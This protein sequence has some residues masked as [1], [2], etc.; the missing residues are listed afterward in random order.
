MT[1]PSTLESVIISSTLISPLLA[2]AEVE[3][4]VTS[5]T[6]DQILVVGD[7]AGA[8]VTGRGGVAWFW[9]VVLWTMGVAVGGE[10]VILLQ[11]SV[12][13]PAVEVIGQGTLLISSTSTLRTSNIILP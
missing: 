5:G 3:A 10:G 8:E 13:I 1:S 11:Y 12:L 7:Q 4:G 9:Q 6:E 2:A